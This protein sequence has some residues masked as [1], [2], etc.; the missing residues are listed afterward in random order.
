VKPLIKA[1]SKASVWQIFAFSLLI[2]LIVASLTP[3]A[4]DE[5]Y[6]YFWSKA[7]QLSY[8]DHPAAVAWIFWPSQFLPD[9]MIRW[10]PTAIAHLGYGFLLLTLKNYLNNEQLKSWLILILLCPVTG[11]GSVIVTPDLPLIFTWFGSLYF[12]HQ[13]LRSDSFINYVFLGTMLGLGF[14]SKYNIVLFVPLAILWILTPGV[15]KRLSLPKLS[16]TVLTGLLFSLP[17]LYWNYTNEWISFIFQLNHGF[18]SNN[19]SAIFPIHYLVFQILALSPLV[20]FYGTRV[21]KSMLLSPLVIFSIPIYLFFLKS[22]FSAPVEPNWTLV[23]LPL[24]FAIAVHATH[25]KRLIL[26]GAFTWGAFLL[27]LASELMFNWMPNPPPQLREAYALKM[28][29]HEID[30]EYPT[31]AST[32]QMASYLD[33]HS[34]KSI[35]KLKGYGRFD[36]YDMIDTFDPKTTRFFVFGES[37]FK[38]PE[39]YTNQGYYIVNEKIIDDKFVKYEIVKK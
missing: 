24:T 18:E 2:K 23:A 3:L 7:P 11:F 28:L 38:L 20:A 35:Y 16:L 21:S 33:Y 34:A 17:V 29:V 26:S 32:Y 12:A 14:C 4:A 13:I 15:F 10:F 36:H 30:P 9:F 27:I 8:F 39:E 37:Y 1:F 5:Y 31:F 25:I 19:W 6:Y 22:S